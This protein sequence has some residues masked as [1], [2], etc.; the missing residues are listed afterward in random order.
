MIPESD[1]SGFN[2]RYGLYL[3]CGSI[4]YGKYLVC[5]S[6]YVANFMRHVYLCAIWY[7]E[8]ACRRRDDDVFVL[9]FTESSDVVHESFAYKKIIKTIESIESQMPSDSL[10][11]SDEVAP[12][13]SGVMRTA[14]YSTIICRYFCK[15]MR[16]C[17]A[18]EYVESAQYSIIFVEILRL[19]VVTIQHR[20][21]KVKALVKPIW[22]LEHPHP[23]RVMPLFSSIRTK[24][25]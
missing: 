24:I 21:A 11:C 15:S 8:I 6:M 10:E 5:V 3:A 13:G 19:C 7:N 25:H 23:S 12:R 2:V 4:I 18:E 22:A 14:R 20:V 17:S 1:G 9:N 16:K